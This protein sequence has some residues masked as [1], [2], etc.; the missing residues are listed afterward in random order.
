MANIWTGII[1]LRIG[2]SGE[3]FVNGNEP[4]GS[5]KGVEFLGKL[6]DS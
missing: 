6:S 3:I 4:S 2:T 5:V 1:W